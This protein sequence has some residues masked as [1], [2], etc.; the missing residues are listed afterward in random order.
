LRGGEGSGSLCHRNTLY[1]REG[2]QAQMKTR[3]LPGFC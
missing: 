3:D 1:A 2:R